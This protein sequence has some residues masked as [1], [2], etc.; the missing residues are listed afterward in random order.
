MQLTDI[1]S[2]I[3]FAIS[4]VLLT[5]L[6]CKK[7]VIASAVNLL[8]V[9]VCA[10]PAIF[11]AKIAAAGLAPKAL[12]YLEKLLGDL[13]FETGEKVT[14]LLSGFCRV[15]LSCVLYTVFYIIIVLIAEIIFSLITKTPKKKHIAASLPIGLITAVIFT[16]LALIPVYKLLSAANSLTSITSELAADILPEDTVTKLSD[17]GDKTSSALGR[18]KTPVDKIYN[19]LMTISLDDSS[20]GSDVNLDSDVNFA[21][22]LASLGEVSDAGSAVKILEENSLL[23]G[24]TD[25]I[26][27]GGLEL[28][29]IATA[30]ES[31]DDL[32]EPTK[33]L[34]Q[35]DTSN[36]GNVSAGVLDAFHI[37]DSSILDAVGNAVA[38]SGI[39]T[40]PEEIIDDEAEKFAYVLEIAYKY[41]E[42]W[43][44][45]ED[46]AGIIDNE[47][48]FAESLIGSTVAYNAA[49]NLL[50]GTYSDKLSTES[51]E[52]WTE[53]INN[54]E[55]SV[56]DESAGEKAE[57]LKSL[58]NKK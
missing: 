9:A 52:N 3:F 42:A 29:E 16:C 14:A 54:Y 10:A 12:P 41:K 22:T 25:E 57:T 33:K 58:L 27:P 15:L 17:V 6:A 40:Q 32:T 8:T 46:T 7:G 1:I 21:E 36:L 43:E 51:K 5:L 56:T 2:I 45:G 28:L 24:A 35:K 26:I 39:N 55:A 48:K 50:C 13:P 19:R 37:T 31:G 4:A 23:A 49:V 34:L 38:E 11:A 30:L 18:L 44:S 47:E 53:I 20:D